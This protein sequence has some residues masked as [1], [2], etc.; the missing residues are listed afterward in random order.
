MPRIEASRPIAS[1]RGARIDLDSAATADHHYP[2][3]GS[4]GQ[5]VIVQVD[6]GRHLED[7]IDP[8]VAGQVRQGVQAPGLVVVKDMEVALSD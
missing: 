6:V 1:H 7:Y 4:Q 3:A 5:E 2:A 8:A